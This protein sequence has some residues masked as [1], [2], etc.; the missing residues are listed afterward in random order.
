MS[1]ID[2]SHLDRDCIKYAYDIETTYDLFTIAFISDHSLTF[3]IFGN[4]KFDHY[5][6]EYFI[7]RM[8]DYANVDTH[9]KYLKIN[10]VDDLDY[11]VLRVYMND[12]AS[13]L[14]FRVE[15]SRIMNSKPLS[16]D[17]EHAQ[18][19]GRSDFAEYQ[20]WNSYSYDTN[21]LVLTHLMLANSL[22]LK[23]HAIRNLS[24]ILI[25]HNGFP[26]KRFEHMAE[27]T[28]GVIDETQYRF[29]YNSL[30]YSDGHIDWAKIIKDSGD[31]TQD[32]LLV[33]GL[34]REMAR[35]GMDIVTDDTVTY[36]HAL[37][38][39]EEDVDKL[40]MYNFNDV[41]GTKVIG[42]LENI[43]TQLDTRDQLRRDYPYTS[44][45]N[46]D[47]SKLHKYEPAPR[48]MTASK[49]SALVIVGPYH[50]K[51]KDSETVEYTF[52]VPDGQGG[53]KLVDLWAY[54]EENEDYVH[55]YIS[56]FF[57]H[58][59]GKDTRDA[60][61][62]KKVKAS[63]PI[64]HGSRMNAPYFD[65]DN[66]PTDC[67]IRL[68][69]GG[70][71]GGE[72]AGL[73]HLTKEEINEWIK[74]DKKI[75]KSVKSTI[76]LKN[77]IHIDWSSFYP[78]MACKMKMYVTSD[79]EDRYNDIRVG[80]IEVK[81]E[82][83]SLA[84]QGKI[85]TPEYDRIDK[86]QDAQKFVL[87]NATGEGNTHKPW[88]KLP[89]DNK[90]LSMRLIG[91]MLIWCM[92]QRLAKVG[93]FIIST[94]TDGLYISGISVEQAQSVLDEYISIY[95]MD[96]DPEPIKR[97]INRDVSSRA[98]GHFDYN[99]PTVVS[100]DLGNAQQTTFLDTVVGRNLTYPLVS[101]HAVVRY[102]FEDEDWLYKPYDRERLKSYI[103]EEYN[104][105]TFNPQA[106]YYIYSGTKSRRLL[107]DGIR[108]DKIARLVLTKNGQHLTNDT[109]SGLSKHH[110]VNVY[111]Q[112]LHGN[113]TKLSDVKS[114]E[115]NQPYDWSNIDPD[116]PIED[117][118]IKFV[119]NKNAGQSNKGT[120]YTPVDV[121]T[122]Y[123]EDVKNFRYN[124]IGFFD[125]Q[126]QEWKPLKYWKKSKM[127]HFTSDVGRNLPLEDNLRYFDKT[128]LDI[129]A[130]LRW[131][132]NILDTWKVTNDLP[133]L[134][135]E[136]LDD[137]VVKEDTQAKKLTKYEQGVQMIY[138]MYGLNTEEMEVA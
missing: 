64:T 138:E 102:M 53:E 20:G 100:G 7:K 78:T 113:I 86:K 116:T 32:A 118:E 70:A 129:E 89:L 54:M 83:K 27:A 75:G 55:P 111:H 16:F 51:P 109:S 71:H 19:Y 38:W 2:L 90:T 12:K 66:N 1:S 22:N 119:V 15:L 76:D 123:I 36:S 10:D 99:T 132:E 30:I 80:R 77:I 106:W 6:D 52:P 88:A 94:N 121:E 31:E 130:Y 9:K 44:A 117:L 79:G 134:N 17:V 108:Q 26:Y 125:T 33:P 124:T 14:K 50:K 42:E 137:T 40:V 61:D 72:Y 131:S 8:R 82:L 45:R 41:L 68:S 91:N 56:A 84:K 48:D 93:A 107:I 28:G 103:L 74:V 133:Q 101:G 122:D 34:K 73:R 49:L 29:L 112:L 95:G 105:E 104:R 24:D 85:G 57:N 35:F 98:E 115:D 69:T 120:E 11:N 3:V 5:S 81:S 47:K 62:D 135:I 87:N 110:S 37:D 114:F 60:F 58:F 23:P 18:K 25:H 96:V 43:Q 127:T 128:E 67:Y 63:Q 65:K 136:K 59:R 4:E 21:M 92:A 13:M 46:A 39:S 97:F 126:A